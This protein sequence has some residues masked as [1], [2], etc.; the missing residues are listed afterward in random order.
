MPAQC[1]CGVL[2][3]TARESTS[4]SIL[5]PSSRLYRPSSALLFD[6]NHDGQSYCDTRRDPNRWLA[7][8][9]GGAAT[10]GHAAA[11]SSPPRDRAK[12]VTIP[13]LRLFWTGER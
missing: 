1:P 5:H 12:S 10:V 3:H 8:K 2:L 9:R 11:S 13:R 4:P 6:Y 7:K